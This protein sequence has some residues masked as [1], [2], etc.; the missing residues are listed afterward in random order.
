MLQ[1]LSKADFASHS[2]FL[3]ELNSSLGSE[4]DAVDGIT[5]AA[6]SGLAFHVVGY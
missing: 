3:S 4:R 5:L 6:E 1:I 2:S